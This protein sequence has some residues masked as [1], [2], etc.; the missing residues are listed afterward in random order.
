MTSISKNKQK[1]T[2]NATISHHKHLNLQVPSS[3]TCLR[4]SSICPAVLTAPSHRQ[5]YSFSTNLEA[6]CASSPP[7]TAP[8]TSLFLRSSSFFLLFPRSL[9]PT[10]ALFFARLQPV[11]RRLRGHGQHAA[12]LP[13][14]P[15][16][17]G[18]A[19]HEGLAADHRRLQPQRQ[20]AA[21]GPG[22]PQAA[23]QAPGGEG[24][25][26]PRHGARLFRRKEK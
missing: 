12:R 5:R 18:A 10:T 1:S 20:G 4:L 7:Q 23:Q 15:R 3:A 19:G 21:T 11:P 26:V 13:V 9:E 14:Q 25:Q 8:K 22:A 16:R 6:N 2:K 24:R 17:Q